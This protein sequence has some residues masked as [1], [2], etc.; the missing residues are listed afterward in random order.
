MADGNIMLGRLDKTTSNE[1]L[2]YVIN[3]LNNSNLESKSIMVLQS[4]H[5][6][7]F[8]K[9]N[10]SFISA[11]NKFHAKNVLEVP[12][13]RKE[14]FAVLTYSKLDKNVESIIS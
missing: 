14:A 2:R 3:L 7:W 1:K 13:L 9:L 5:Q 4:K 11:N 8:K 10:Y 6:I 12:V